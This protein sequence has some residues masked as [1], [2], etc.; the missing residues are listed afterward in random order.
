[1]LAG[2]LDFYILRLLDAYKYHSLLG[3]R[4]PRKG[5]KRFGMASLDDS[6]VSPTI[7]MTLLALQITTD[8][9]EDS[10]SN[11]VAEEVSEPLPAAS[12]LDF[13]STLSETPTQTEAAIVT[14]AQQ[15]ADSAFMDTSDPSQ[16][17]SHSQTQTQSQSL[18]QP[19]PESTNDT[20]AIAVTL[21]SNAP[22]VTATSSLPPKAA[23]ADFFKPRQRQDASVS[24]VK[25]SASPKLDV[26]T[27]ATSNQPST[28]STSTKSHDSATPLPITPYRPDLARL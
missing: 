23:V 16:S 26:Q 20:E 1:M 27:S 6:V 11:V 13:S 7:L 10:N 21:T 12:A 4:Q 2:V 17:P 19:Q 14:D 28:L 18:S 22:L 8:V 9:T 24:S 25:P 15:S 3:I 5:S